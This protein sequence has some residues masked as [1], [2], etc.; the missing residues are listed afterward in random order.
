MYNLE[1]ILTAMGKRTTNYYDSMII[2]TIIKLF[3]FYRVTYVCINV[4]HLVEVPGK[5]NNVLIYR[6]NI[7]NWQ[8]LLSNH[9]Y[10]DLNKFATLFNYMMYVYISRQFCYAIDPVF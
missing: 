1:V 4:W 5:N 7:H 9:I 8:E 6:K 3:N 10:V 2:T